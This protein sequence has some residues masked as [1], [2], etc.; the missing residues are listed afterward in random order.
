MFEGFQRRT[1]DVGETTINALVGGSGAPLLLLHGYPQTHVMWHRI[2]PALAERFTVV[3]TDL[4]GYG[5]SGVPAS[6]DDHF[7]FSKRATAADQ[8]TVMER[9]GHR[10]FMVAGHDRGA[11]VTHRLVLDWPD[12]V[13][14]AAVLDIVPTP[15]VFAHVDKALATAYWHWFFLIQ[16]ADLP[17]RMIG[18]DP[19]FYL[20]RLLGGLTQTG[21]ITDEAF[22]EYRRCFAQEARIHATCEDYRAGA[23]I[24]LTHHAAD[25]GRKITCPLLVL[26]GASSGVGRMYKPLEVW[27][28]WADDVSGQAVPGGH[29]L[30]EEA[31][32]ETLDAML[33]FFGR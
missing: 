15:H 24:D 29:F 20:Q 19:E 2:A 17:E 9:L 28:G 27:R 33:A 22:A 12:R 3:A 21:A 16:K 13:S 14:R 30:P 10:R 6:S 18:A 31:P 8:V 1:I 4:R 7:S 5:D 11:R 25:Q 32:R 26:W 23:S